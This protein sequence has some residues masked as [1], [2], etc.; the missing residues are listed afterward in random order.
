MGRVFLNYLQH[1]IFNL[2]EG[3]SSMRDER[4]QK[5]RNLCEPTSTARE[6]KNS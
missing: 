5:E 4:N 1:K 3:G 6:V 2:G